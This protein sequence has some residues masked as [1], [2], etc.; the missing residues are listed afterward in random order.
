MRFEDG[1]HRRKGESDEARAERIRADAELSTALAEDD[2][3]LM[4]F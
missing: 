4:G 1:A 3:D 2:D